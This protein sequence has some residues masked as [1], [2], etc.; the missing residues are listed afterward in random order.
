MAALRKRALASGVAEDLVED[1]LD[2]DNPR[3]TLVDLLVEAEPPPSPTAA[4]TSSTDASRTSGARVGARASESEPEPE[5]AEPVLTSQSWRGTR[6]QSQRIRLRILSSWSASCKR[7]GLLGIQLFDS[8]GLE[9][10]I[11]PRDI[12]VRGIR[13]CDR[14]LNSQCIR[15]LVSIHDTTVCLRS[16]AIAQG[17]ERG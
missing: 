10:H 6:A 5:P 16:F 2:A 8:A 1:A 11:W 3:Q 4:L 13:R 12:S 9:V 14:Y 17:H 15:C 7:A